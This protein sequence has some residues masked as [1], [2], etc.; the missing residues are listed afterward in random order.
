MVSNRYT[1]PLVGIQH[2]DEHATFIDDTL[3]RIQQGRMPAKSLTFDALNN[4]CPMYHFLYTLGVKQ[5]KRPDNF[6]RAWIAR[7]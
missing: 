4:Q 5:A 1:Q 6:N 2:W 7:L 3:N